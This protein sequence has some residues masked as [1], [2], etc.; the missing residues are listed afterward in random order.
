MT[1]DVPNPGSDEAIADGCTCPR[2]D[3]EFGEWRAMGGHFVIAHG[4]PL[5]W[6]D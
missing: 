1:A 6:A 3:N 2:M 4:C 5:H